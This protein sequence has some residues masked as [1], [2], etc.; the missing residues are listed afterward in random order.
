MPR[1]GIAKAI[2]DEWRTRAAERLAEKGWTKAMWADTAG[3][4][5]SLITE[6]L[7]GKRSATTYL[8]ELHQALDWPTP[9]PPLAAKDAGEMLYLWDRLDEVS[10]A[11]LLE[12]A[13]VI[14]EEI[15]KKPK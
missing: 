15:S 3:C 2:D 4:P 14:F 1:E 8:D 6:L 11:R 9:M 10:R 7:D 5:R 12:R 13:R